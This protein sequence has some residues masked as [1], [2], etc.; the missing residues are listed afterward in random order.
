MQDVRLRTGVAM[1][2][3][4]AAFLSLAGA[5][6]AAIWCLIF[7]RKVSLRKHVR[8]F[9]SLG[10]LVGFFAIV[11]AISGGDGVSY[12]I[13]MMVIVLIGAWVYSEQKKGEFLRLGVWLLGE[14]AGF[15]M[16]LVADMG[17]QA[18]DLLIA[19]FEKIRIAERLKRRPL[20]AARIVPAGIVLVNN[21]LRRADDTAE[22][23]AV[24]GYSDGGSLCPAF[25]TTRRDIV[26]SLLACC[27]A[28][29]AI[30]PVSE[31]F[32]LYR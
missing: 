3:S 5:V 22:L 26:A 13:R 28:V 14:K 10:V 16:G 9:L 29:L 1:L 31:F 6:A 2:L 25:E 11:L 21:A 27:I 4:A 18:M 19:D 24:R 12:F 7:A 15:D 20:N 23:L 32:I 8:L 17:M 30:I